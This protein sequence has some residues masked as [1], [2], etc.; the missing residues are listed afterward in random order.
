MKWI[1]AITG[2]A[3]VLSAGMLW[4][5]TIEY[6]FTMPVGIVSVFGV[7]A[8][9]VIQLLKPRLS[10]KWRGIFA[11]GL[12]LGVGILGVTV[13]GLWHTGQAVHTIIYVL[14]ASQLSYGLFWKKLLCNVGKK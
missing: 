8:P 3:V 4:A 12:S 13:A 9:I 11:I 5:G 14:L 10:Q 2:L 7:L 6:E 1:L